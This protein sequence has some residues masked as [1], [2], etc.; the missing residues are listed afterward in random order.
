MR[1]VEIYSDGGGN[2]NSGAGGACVVR[3]KEGGEW[4]FGIFLGP[5]TNNEGEISAGLLGFSFLRTLFEEAQALG[6][7]W[8]CDSEYVLKSATE[9]IL[10]WQRNGWRTASRKPVKNQGLWK[11]YLFLVQGYEVTPEHVYGHTGHPENEACDRAST[12]LQENGEDVF[13]GRSLIE[14]VSIG[15]EELDQ[16]W[17]MLDGREFIAQMRENNQP[18]EGISS[19]LIEMLI[20]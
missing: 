9:Y 12:W 1:L 15:I 3:D 19:G 14:G 5:G 8:V 17:T 6:V 13:E 4:K 20:S 11:T 16:D 7:H 18:E 2:V 10:N